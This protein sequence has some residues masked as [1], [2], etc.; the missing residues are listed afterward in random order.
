M[1]KNKKLKILI[2]HGPNLN[3]L[4]KREP[5]LYGTLTLKQINKK[6]KKYAGLKSI[7]VKTFQS[8][9]EGKLIDCI[10][11]ADKK[12]TGII[13]NPGAYTHYSLAIR[14]AIAAVSLPVVEVHLTDIHNRED[15]RKI[16]V[17]APVCLDQISALGVDSYIKGMERIVEYVG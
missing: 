17:T 3:M 14:D 5:E 12:Y 2:I 11:T 9:H 7:K 6:I 4:G 8:N 10:Q 1:K 16:S 15:F 13:I